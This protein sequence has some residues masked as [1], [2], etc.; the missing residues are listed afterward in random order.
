VAK[1][2]QGGYDG[3]RDGQ[4]VALMFEL[5]VDR[6]ANLG[7]LMLNSG[8]VPCEQG[9]GR[10]RG[11]A[12]SRAEAELCAAAVHIRLAS[13]FKSPRTTTAKESLLLET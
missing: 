13:H 11:D 9:S 10:E 5:D 8:T 7:M 4:H 1:R 2:R 3:G 6:I 12:S